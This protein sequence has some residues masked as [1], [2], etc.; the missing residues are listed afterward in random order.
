MSLKK[1]LIVSPLSGSQRLAVYRAALEAQRAG[2][3][4]VPIPPNGTKHPAFAWEKYQKECASPR[5]L[6]QWFLASPGEKGLAFLTGEVSGSL[7][8]LDFDSREVY[9]AWRTRMEREG[10]GALADRLAKG[11]LEQTPNGMHLWY[12]CRTIEKN[13]PLARRLLEPKKWKT[14]IETRGEGGLGIAAPSAGR[15]HTSGEPYVV[16]QGSIATIQTIT[17]PE[18]QRL[19]EVARL[20]DEKLPEQRDPRPRQL[21]SLSRNSQGNE[22]PGHIFNRLG[23]WEEVLCPHGWRFLRKKDGVGYWTKHK[24]VHATTN[25]KGSGYLYVFSTAT[26]FD[27]QRGYSKFSAYTLLN[28]GSLTEEAFKAAAKELAAK[29]YV[30]T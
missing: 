8:L 18:R 1:Q 2:I 23:T 5:Q 11:Y 25:H 30:S 26:C 12:R 13:Q 16:L 14:F 21:S 10:V 9:V 27:P 4:V 6:Y 3:S 7:E 24:D 20:F 28:Y 29:G 17:A 15:V 22:L 19:F